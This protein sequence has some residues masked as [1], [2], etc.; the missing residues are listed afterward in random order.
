MKIP[1]KIFIIALIVI[2]ILL[3]AGYLLLQLS[4]SRTFQFF[5]GLTSRR[6]TNNK[7]IALTFDD[8]PTNQVDWVLKTLK[9][10]NIKATFYEI[11]ENIQKNPAIAK[12]IADAGMEI[13]NHSYSHQ[14]FLFKPQSFIEDEIQKTNALIRASGY[15]GEITFRPPYGKKLIGLPWYLSQHHIQSIMCDVEADTYADPK[16]TG[17]EKTA[18]LVNY[19][20]S[21]TR[22]GSIILLHPFCEQECQSDREAL[23]KIID[24]LKVQGYTLV[25]ISEL[26]A[27]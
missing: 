7:I 26:L 1:K 6:V 3:I 23:P 16:L 18:F 15:K 12:E 14:R 13:G 21:H 27:G 17:D 25:T 20:V 10:E 22:A 4:K 19:T 24:S 5:G 11:G 2:S 9:E 8:A